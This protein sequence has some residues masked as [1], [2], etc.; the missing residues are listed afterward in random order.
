MESADAE[1]QNSSASAEASNALCRYL[2][3][4]IRELRQRH[5]LTIAEVSQKAGISRGMLSKIENVQTSASLETLERLVSVLGVSL[6]AL[7][8]GYEAS[9]EQVFLVPEGT[10]KEVVRRGTR[11]GHTYQLLA[12]DPTAQFCFESFLITL[13]ERSEPFA[14][15]EHPGFE[16]IYVLEGKMQYRH[17]SQSYLLKAGD[18]LTFQSDIPHGPELLI[19]LPIRFLATVFNSKGPIPDFIASPSVEISE[20]ESSED[21]E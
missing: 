9:S 6:S 17:G 7:F 14:A 8:K 11:N 12:S 19:D 21:V 20:V 15:F 16:S 18:A 5:D 4:T 10:A 1:F 2:G 13:H 3:N